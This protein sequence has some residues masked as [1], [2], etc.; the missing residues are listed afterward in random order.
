VLCEIMWFASI[1]VL[2]KEGFSSLKNET[3]K[4]LS[5]K[6]GPI[7]ETR[8]TIGLIVFFTAFLLQIIVILMFFCY[9]CNF[10]PFMRITCVKTYTVLQLTTLTL[11]AASCYLLGRDF[12]HG[13][14]RSLLHNEEKK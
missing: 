3:R 9:L 2:G 4:F 13:V 11:L 5:L 7:S 14:L 6:R 10:I 12:V 8:H 1:P